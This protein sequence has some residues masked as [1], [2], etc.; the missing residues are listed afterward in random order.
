MVKGDAVRVKWWD[1]V[2]TS[3][4][5]IKYI[6]RNGVLWYHAEINLIIEIITG[7]STSDAGVLL[8]STIIQLLTNKLR[9]DL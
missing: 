4:R 6:Y 5:E 7:S 3:G 1:Q 2:A 8:A 9:Q